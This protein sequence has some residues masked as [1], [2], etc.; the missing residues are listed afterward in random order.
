[1]RE[2]GAGNGKGMRRG[3]DKADGQRWGWGGSGAGGIG[4]RKG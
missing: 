2:N 4:G 3:E 1:M